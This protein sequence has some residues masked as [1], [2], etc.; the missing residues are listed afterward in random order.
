MADG[1]AAPAGTG[2]A[3]RIALA[4]YALSAPALVLMFAM[5]LLPVAVVAGLST[6]DWLFGAKT[7]NFVGLDN[8]REMWQD[9]VFWK[10]LGNTFVYV[11][12]VVPG[13]FALGLAVA[14][15]IRSAASLA[16]PRNMA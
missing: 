4:A 7:L 15:L 6:T 5:L 8:Y 10:A 13:S 2:R 1:R 14:L 3:A 9:K 16:T 11:A 12:T